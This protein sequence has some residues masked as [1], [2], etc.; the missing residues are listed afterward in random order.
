MLLPLGLLPF[1]S[2]KPSRWLLVAPLLINLLTYYQYQYDLGF[3]YHFG[4]AAFLI[5]AMLGNLPSLSIHWRRTLLGVS[6][7]ACLCLY[8]FEVVPTCNYYVEK[9]E[10]GQDD[11]GRME[12]IL[13][14]VPQDAS[15]NCSTFLLAHIADREVIYEVGYHNDLPDVDYVVLDARYA[16]WEEHA[17][18]Y[19]DQGYEY[20]TVE[21]N[22]IV[23]LKRIP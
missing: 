6:V 12:E 23:I 3:Q 5:Y 8:V 21:E 14:T 19:L 16:G 7:A 18:A 17:Q 2:K 15:V 13:D 1:C 11:Y 9:W 4:I 20:Q 10:T 22:M